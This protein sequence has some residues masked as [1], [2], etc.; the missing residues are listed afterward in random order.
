MRESTRIPEDA[1]EFFER[2]FPRQFARDRARYPR[3]DSPGAALFEVIGVGVWSVAIERGTL[4]VERGKAAKTL[5]QVAVSRDDFRAIFV[6]RAQREV[7]SSGHL[8]EDSRD[9]FKPLFVDARK[10]GVVA[11]VIGDTLATLAFSL[12]DA[13][14]ARHILITPG[15]FERTD[16]RT[17]IQMALGDFLAMLGGRRNPGALFVLRRLKI[18]GDVLYAVR[19]RALL[20]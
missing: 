10:A 8:S 1:G 13:G 9:V 20:S 3:A 2:F 14:T 4:V 19:M 6:R 15:P 18:R 11:N 5:L 17:T 16:P 7:D 12:D